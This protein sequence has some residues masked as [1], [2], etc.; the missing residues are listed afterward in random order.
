MEDKSKFTLNCN[1]NTSIYQQNEVAYSTREVLDIGWSCADAHWMK[2]A[3]RQRIAVPFHVVDRLRLWIF[4][5]KHFAKDI[6][7]S[8]LKNLKFYLYNN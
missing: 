6:V 4:R 3:E 2:G 7:T 5:P 8:D 1:K